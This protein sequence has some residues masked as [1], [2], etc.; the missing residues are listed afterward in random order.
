M[1]TLMSHGKVPTCADCKKWMYDID[2]WKPVTRG[3]KNV[4]RAPGDP[5]PCWK[6]PKSLDGQPNPGGD[7]KGRNWQTYLLWLQARAGCSMPDDP[8]LRQNLAIIQYIVDSKRSGSLDV[9]SLL[10]TALSRR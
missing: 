3:G 1:A 2:T 5:L 6:C 4:R 8:L 9:V 10:T 7:M